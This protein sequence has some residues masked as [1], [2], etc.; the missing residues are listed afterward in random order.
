MTE[1]QFFILQLLGRIASAILCFTRA[2]KLNRSHF[3]WGVLG[4]VFPV[5][6]III[7][8]FMKPRKLNWMD[9]MSLD[10]KEKNIY[11]TS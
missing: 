7:I 6:S 2:D 3:I 5:M 11:T 8:L 4:G 1:Q 10:K 9:K